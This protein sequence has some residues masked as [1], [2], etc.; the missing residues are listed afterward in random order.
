MELK[1]LYLVDDTRQF[2]TCTGCHQTI[3]VVG[4]ILKMYTCPPSSFGRERNWVP[5][6]QESLRS[7]P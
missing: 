7:T 2:Y 6:S 5:V 4:T 1:V 3:E